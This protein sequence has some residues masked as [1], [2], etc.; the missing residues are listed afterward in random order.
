MTIRETSWKT[1]TANPK[2]WK[3]MLQ[4]CENA[5]ES[6]DL[7]Q[8][9][10][11]ADEI[12]NK[13]IE[14][15][16]RKA[17]EGVKVRF[18]WDAAGSFT[19][20]GSS[21]VEDLK[22]KGIELVFFK[23]LFP[24]FFT[25][26]D[27]RSWYFRNHRRTL[28]I[29]GK[30]GFTGSICISKEM[31]EWRDTHVKIEGP[32]VEDMKKAFERMLDRAHG[33]RVPR[34]IPEKRSGGVDHEFEYITNT[35]MGR[36]RRLYNRIVEA[37][38]NADKYIYIT[39]PYFVPTHRIARILRQAAHHGV[40]V[41]IIIPEK[42]DYPIVDLGARTFF[43]SLLWS[44][45]KIYLYK[46]KMMHSKTVVVDDKWASVGTLNIDHISLLYNFEANLVTKN[47]HFAE[48]LSSHFAHDLQSSQEITYEEWKNI[49]F[50]KKIVLFFVKFIRGFL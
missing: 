15:C 10:F 24:G 18:L 14:V 49:S 46:G 47:R 4:A 39:T 7:E 2:A 27:Y 1:Y 38:R 36:N 30:T 43:H 17:R 35:P 28:V 16:T 3:A 26:H 50:V 44:G 5:E 8:F 40:D 6:I 19:F 9:I 34:R 37:L 11:M 32:V 33:K 29:D 48:E 42:S 22:N 31:K 12:G 13:F 20:F 21:M 41:K 45:V 23:T 25:I